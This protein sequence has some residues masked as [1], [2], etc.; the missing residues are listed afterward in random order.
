MEIVISSHIC[1]LEVK[2]HLTSVLE[3][4]EWENLN[5]AQWKQLSCSIETLIKPFAHQ[6]NETN[7][8][9]YNGGTG[10]EGTWTSYKKGMHIIY[11]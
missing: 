9:E 1:M 11:N 7:S 6:T 5:V 2:E 3:E 10:V 4:L 8:E